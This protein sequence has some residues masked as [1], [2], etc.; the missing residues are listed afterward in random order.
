LIVACEYD[1][2]TAGVNKL[3]DAG[4][5]ASGQHILRAASIYLV[6]HLP[7]HANSRQGSRMKHT[8]DSAT[9]F[10]NSIAIADVAAH[11]VDRLRAQLRIIPTS[12]IAHSI[13][14]CQQRLN[15][16]PAQKTAAA[17]D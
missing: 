3:L 11:N 14:A 5:D 7:A 2:R 6:V 1:A 10:G 9:S 12:K 15:D 4:R 16:V 13:S 17:R 8:F